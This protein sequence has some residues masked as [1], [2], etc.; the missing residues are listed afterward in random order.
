MTQ[1][2]EMPAVIVPHYATPTSGVA[3][4]V[5]SSVVAVLVYFEFFSRHRWLLLRLSTKQYAYRYKY[6]YRVH[7]SGELRFCN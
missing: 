7:I 2:F 6:L 5:L 1:V 3:F 4:T